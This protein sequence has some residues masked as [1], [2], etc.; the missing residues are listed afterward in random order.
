[1]KTTTLG[2]CLN[3][4]PRLGL[5]PITRQRLFSGFCGP[6]IRLLDSISGSNGKWKIEVAE[7]GEVLGDGTSMLLI[8]YE[9]KLHDIYD[10]G[11]SK[12]YHSGSSPESF[13][14]WGKLQENLVLEGV[15]N[16]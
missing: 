14:Q 16:G 7:V 10:W 13:R 8:I 12:N 4:Y 11:H 2:E 1:M 9:E 15:H 3:K 6:D 5:A